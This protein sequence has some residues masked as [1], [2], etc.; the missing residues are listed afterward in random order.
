MKAISLHTFVDASQ[1]PYT[2]VVYVRSEYVNKT[3]SVTLAAAKAKVA[4]LQSVSIPQLKLMGAHLGNKL[5]HSIANVLSIPKQHMIFW[6]NSTDVLWWIR[7]YKV[8][9]GFLANK[10]GEIQLHSNPDQWKCIS[11]KFNMNPADHLTRG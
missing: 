8:I 7:G 11:T 5:S 9:V 6:S 2:G 1:C 3:V 4:P 10:I